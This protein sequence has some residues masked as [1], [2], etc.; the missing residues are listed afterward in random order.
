MGIIAGLLKISPFY[1]FYK[2]FREHYMYKHH[3][4]LE[5][6]MLPMRVQFYK[7]FIRPNELVFDVGANVGNRVNA[8]LA[9]KAKI[10]AVEPQPSWTNFKLQVW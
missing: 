2:R 1:R 9:C 10:V 6:K 7:Q 8:M 5:A 3:Q 4:K